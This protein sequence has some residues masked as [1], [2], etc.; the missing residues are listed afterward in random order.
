RLAGDLDLRERMGR[1]A[2]ES[3]CR[4]PVERQVDQIVD[5]YCEAMASPGSHGALPGALVLYVSASPWDTRVRQGFDALAEG[6]RT[7]RRRVMPLDAAVAEERLAASAD[8][9]LVLSND[10]QAWTAAGRALARG[11]P[12]VVPEEMAELRALCVAS[13]AGLFWRDGEELAA[14]VA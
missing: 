14:C 10:A 7:L 12:V 6:E 13:N 9:L 5:V 11:V 3:I 8:L 1:A 4:Y 2:R